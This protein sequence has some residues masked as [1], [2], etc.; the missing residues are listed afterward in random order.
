MI[1]SPRRAAL[2]W[3]ILLPFLWLQI[4]R[5]Q[6]QMSPDQ[7]VAVPVSPEELK[8]QALPG[9][10]EPSRYQV[11]PGDA[12][13]LGIWGE[14][15]FSYDLT[16]TPEGNLILPGI[17]SLPV[18]GLTLAEV[19]RQIQ[20]KVTR[21]FTNV[22]V[23]FTLTKVRVF[24]VHVTG[25]VEKP[26]T[27]LASAV[28]RV[29]DLVRRAGGLKEG[30]SQRN[31]LLVRD[32]DTI[33][34]DLF[35][36]Y[37]TGTLTR[38]PFV[39]EGDRIVVPPR[40]YVAWV[41]GAVFHPGE[42]EFIPGETLG[43]ILPL[44]GGFRP[45]VDL[46]SVEIAQFDEN[47]FRIRVQILPWAEAR[48]HV[49]QIDDR[50]II[51]S[52]SQWHRKRGV[53]VRGEVRRPG[54]YAINRGELHLS[55]LI[56]RAGGFTADANLVEAKVIRGQ[57]EE[58]VDPEFERLKKMNPA[59]M[60]EMEYAYYKQKMQETPGRMAVDFER[61]FLQGD[62][63]QDILLKDGDVVVVPKKRDYITVSGQVLFPG[64][65]PY[66]KDFG[67]KDYIRLA[68]GFAWNARKNKVRVI[69]ARTGE[70][71]KPSEVEKL[72]PGDAIWI[73]EKP[74][75]DWWL[76]FRQ[77]MTVAAQGA[78]LYLVVKSAMGK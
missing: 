29:S 10:I 9:K 48:K 22:D 36:F 11:G 63:S 6:S 77:F 15:D 18:A 16:V 26:G 70:W 33:R 57:E 40:R 20:E 65:I 24:R 7:T 43:E 34:T 74:E 38:N 17:G 30:A 55:E 21:I 73:P 3:G 46:D 41:Y 35:A 71:L 47:G 8:Y 78:T 60:T 53:W 75:R 69:R 49:L 61:L 42:Y 13:N 56:R 32:D 54:Y 44:T 52:P 25:E 19:A 5:A 51:R 14:K 50:V 62:Q 66:R 2:F 23:T 76:L 45:G 27:Y 72:E 67:V 37:R 31:I 68:G 59:D 12:F 39:R 4:I 28:E 64:N 58:R 1:H